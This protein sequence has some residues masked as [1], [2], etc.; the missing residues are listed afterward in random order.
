[1]KHL[2]RQGLYIFPFAT[3]AMASLANGIRKER[4][5]RKYGPRNRFESMGP[6]GTTPLPKK[7]LKP[8]P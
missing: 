5:G 3:D 4:D 1:M 2:T 8:V 6:L 7:K